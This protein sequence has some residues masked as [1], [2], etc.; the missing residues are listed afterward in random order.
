MITLNP[1]AK[2]NWSLYVLDKRKDGYHNIISLMQCVGLY[3]FMT[4]EKAPAIEFQSD[5]RIPK[6]M[7]LVFRAAIALKEAAGTGLGARIVLRK[8]VPTGAG[9]GGGS[10]DAA[11]TLIGLN[12]LWGLDMGLEEL[13]GIAASLGSD[14]PFFLNC[15]AALV[16]G[17]GEMMLPVHVSGFR[18]LLLVKPEASIPTAWAYEK[19][20]DSEG[21][22]NGIFDLTNTEEKLNNIKLIIKTLNEGPLS[23][24]RSVLH[25]DFEQIAIERHPVIGEIRSKMLAAG[26]AAALLSGSGSAVFG[27]FEEEKRAREVANFFPLFWHRVVK[28]L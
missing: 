2:I 6:E 21:V 7:N 13:Q 4:F 16:Q 9:L 10:S 18:T 1:P 23:L 14:V 25:N 22:R 26:A 8:E 24:L 12:R 17:R 27:L 3:D 20:A 19:V 11:F 15:P 5:M 28:T